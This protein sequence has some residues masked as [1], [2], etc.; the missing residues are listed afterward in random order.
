MS[1]KVHI[2]PHFSILGD[3]HQFIGIYPCL[4]SQSEMDH[5]HSIHHIHPTKL[6]MARPV[7]GPGYGGHGG[8]VVLKATS[9]IESFLDVPEKLRAE[10]G[11][12]G[13]D[14]KRG[15]HGEDYVLQAQRCVDL[16]K[17]WVFIVLL[18]GGLEHG[19]YFSIYWE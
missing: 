9:Q 3:G 14:T 11:G 1:R 18:V 5:S 4:D 7:S 17:A 2:V 15:K 19:L 8:S 6:T 13:H 10:H 12:D 16:K